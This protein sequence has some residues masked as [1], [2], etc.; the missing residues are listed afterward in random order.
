MRT[1]PSLRL[2][3]LAPF[4]AALALGACGGDAGTQTVATGSG[5]AAVAS[6]T[7]GPVAAS[8]VEV[9]TEVVETPSASTA[10]SAASAGDSP[11]QVPSAPAAG[12]E[13]PFEADT[14]PDSAEPEGGLLTVTDVE[15]GAH[16][17][18]DR[19]VFTFGGEGVPGWHVQ[20]VDAPTKQGSGEPFEV[21]GAAYLSVLLRGVGYPFDTGVEEYSGD[22]TISATGT[23]VVRDVAVQGVFEGQYD[24]A[25]GLGAERP[26]RVFRL[27][28]PPRVVVDVAHQG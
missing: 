11:S 16:E 17:G 1:R 9:S 23:Q 18:F 10:T 20:Y 2:T 3:F 15:V 14:Q 21:T 12:A 27:D 6:A 26:F 19:V 4:A 28:G 7:P 22:R 8:P 25:V 5:D 13:A 24:A